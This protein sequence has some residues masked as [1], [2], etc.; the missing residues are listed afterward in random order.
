MNLRSRLRFLAIAA[1]M[2][3]GA[4]L[5][6]GWF[7]A[8]FVATDVYEHDW[9]RLLRVMGYLP[10]WV[11]AALALVLIDWPARTATSIR[12]ALRRGLLMIFA[13]AAGG[14]A[15]EV[16]KLLFRRERPRA[17]EGEY[18]FRAFSD[19]P[20]HSG[21]LAL[22]SS[23][24]LVAFAAAAMLARLF[25]R[26]APV[27]YALALGCGLTRVA[28]RAHFVSDIAVAALA[29]WLVVAWIWQRAGGSRLSRSRPDPAQAAPYPAQSAALRPS[30]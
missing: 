23:H 17:H 7:Y 25:P 14:I 29:A 11:V 30:G 3:A 19:R 12:P 20:F 8:H 21:G 10:T 18:F 13:V 2:I 1:F 5:L 4:H 26:A 27:W 6:D 22:P 28:A 9:G 16:L 24:A 15:A